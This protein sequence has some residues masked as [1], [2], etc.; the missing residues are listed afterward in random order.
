MNYLAVD[1]KPVQ[2]N[3]K[4]MLVRLLKGQP[5]TEVEVKVKRHGY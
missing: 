3:S 5:K 4:V 2:N 1:G